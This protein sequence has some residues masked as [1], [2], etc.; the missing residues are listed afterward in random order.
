MPNTLRADELVG[1]LLNLARPAAEQYYFKT[2]MV[3]EMGM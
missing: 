3:I 2:G 1:K